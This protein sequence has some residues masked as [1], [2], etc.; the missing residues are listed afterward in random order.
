MRLRGF[1]L[2]ELLVVIAI[3]GILSSVVLG[4]LALGRVK[5][6]DATIKSNLR[7]IRA[8]M[9]IVYDD[10]NGSYGPAASTQLSDQT[11]VTGGTVFAT[12]S[13]VRQQLTGAIQQ[14]GGARWAVGINGQSYAVEVALRSQSGY[15]CVDS[16]GVSKVEATAGSLGL[17]TTGASCP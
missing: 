10:N 11:S 15:W 6:A 9:E 7:N 16:S 8:Q 2:I 1:T 14:G 4:S 17:S 3:V 13:N 5:A 12:D